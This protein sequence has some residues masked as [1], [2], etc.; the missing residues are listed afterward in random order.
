MKVLDLTSL[1]SLPFK[2]KNGA[3]WIDSAQ[4]GAMGSAA[5]PGD[6]VEAWLPLAWEHLNSASV[7]S[8]TRRDGEA[9]ALPAP[10]GL[11]SWLR[12]GGVPPE[13]ALQLWC[14]EHSTYSLCKS[15]HHP[16][17]PLYLPPPLPLPPHTCTWSVISK[18][19]PLDPLP[20]KTHFRANSSNSTPE[21]RHGCREGQVQNPC[22]RPHVQETPWHVFLHFFVCGTEWAVVK[23]FPWGSSSCV[24]PGS[25]TLMG[26]ITEC[27]WGQVLDS[28][29]SLL[30][31][32][33]LC[34]F[35]QV[36]TS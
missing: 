16:R 8:S 34:L 21:V 2:Q 9:G 5:G 27:L 33:A 19:C 10:R 3:R 30:W 6:A 18:M 22:P 32:Q 29:L 12:G 25:T 7:L 35:L 23:N 14:G 11:F 31:N 4:K 17:A 20:R 28:S 24:L 13:V 26:S 36:P 1:E 15:C